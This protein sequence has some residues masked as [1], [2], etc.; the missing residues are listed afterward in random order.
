[1]L[2]RVHRRPGERRRW[3]RGAGREQDVDGEPFRF[4]ECGTPR[5]GDEAYDESCISGRGISCV[6]WCTRRAFGVGRYSE[7]E[8]L[9]SLGYARVAELS[10]NFPNAIIQIFWGT[11]FPKVS[12]ANNLCSYLLHIYVALIS[13]PT[14]LKARRVH[15]GSHA[16]PDPE[17]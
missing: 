4:R 5:N 11:R 17:S 2:P 9:G 6:P 8:A 1:M 16:Y 12:S 14:A 10:P 15:H 13:S 3:E 7:R